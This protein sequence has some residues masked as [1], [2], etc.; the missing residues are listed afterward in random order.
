[1]RRRTDQFRRRLFR[2]ARRRRGP[3]HETNG[4]VSLI[5]ARR[6][7][8]L[9]LPS[10]LLLTLPAQAARP[11]IDSV[12]ADSALTAVTING[13][14]FVAAQPRTPFL[15]GFSSPLVVVSPSNTQIAATLPAGPP[16]G[17]YAVR[18]QGAG[19]GEVER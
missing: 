5:D 10:V 18:R 13:P 9:F 1:M 2:P 3:N 15:S 16:A 7:T 6:L 4:E 14:N 11:V 17:Q 19:N 8:S 12:T